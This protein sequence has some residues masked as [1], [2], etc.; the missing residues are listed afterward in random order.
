MSLPIQ[1][2]LGKDILEFCHSEDQSHLRESFQQVAVPA[3][4]RCGT[5]AHVDAA[6]TVSPAVG[7][8]GCRA[9]PEASVRASRAAV[10]EAGWRCAV[11]GGRRNGPHRRGQSGRGLTGE[12]PGSGSTFWTEGQHQWCE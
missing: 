9:L 5:W 1:D 4:S 11:G 2:L 6:G 10:H 8:A 3:G 12:H 7:P